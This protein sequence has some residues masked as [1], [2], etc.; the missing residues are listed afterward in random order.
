MAYL[1]WISDAALEAEVGKIMNTA[2]GALKKSSASFGKNVIDPF[3]VMFEMSGFNI[4]T[5]SAW[6]SSEKSRQAQKTLSNAFGIF[7]QSVLGHV[8]GW[9][10]LGTGKNADLENASSRIIAEVKNK[11]NTLKGSGQVTVYDDL[12][13]LVMPIASRYHGY[14]AYYVEII[15]KP[16][17]GRPQMYDEAFTPSDRATKTRRNPNPLIRRIDGKSFYALVTG[18]PDALNQLHGVLPD[19]IKNV[20]GNEINEGEITHIRHYFGKAFA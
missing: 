10:D 17:R 14:T 20:S 6:E 1:N 3:A 15:P 12:H 2:Q 9:V 11:F 18:V 13:N 7:H 4:Q 5:V 19:V 8:T 16:Q